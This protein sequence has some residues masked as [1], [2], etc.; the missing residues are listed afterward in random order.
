VDLQVRPHSQWAH[1]IDQ[2]GNKHWSFGPICPSTRRWTFRLTTMKAPVLVRFCER[3]FTF[4]VAEYP[5]VPFGSNAYRAMVAPVKIDRSAKKEVGDP[6]VEKAPKPQ[7]MK[8]RVR[9]RTVPEVGYNM[10]RPK[11]FPCGCQTGARLRGRPGTHT[12]LV[13]H[14]ALPVRP[15]AT[16]L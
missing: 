10:A 5:R 2:K 6:S 16:L 8:S 15:S 9:S 11:V 14:R 4:V 3:I 7:R 13:R 12:A 1:D